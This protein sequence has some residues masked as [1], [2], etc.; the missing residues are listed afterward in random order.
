M[1]SVITIPNYDGNGSVLRIYLLNHTYM[2][3]IS[4]TWG[5]KKQSIRIHLPANVYSFLQLSVNITLHVT[6]LIST[7]FLWKLHK[8]WAT[9]T[10]ETKWPKKH[11]WSK[12]R[13]KAV[14]PKP[15]SATCTAVHTH[16][17]THTH[18]HW[19]ECIFDRVYLEMRLLQR[20]LGWA[21]FHFW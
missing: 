17:H 8:S 11:C 1:C 16:T 5:E 2:D 3:L 21:L 10:T 12:A 14:G 18:S 9:V 7:F 13:R 19:L 15:C 6:T 20:A 4:V